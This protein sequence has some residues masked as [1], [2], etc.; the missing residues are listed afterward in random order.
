[1][2]TVVL[3]VA[4]LVFLRQSQEAW[5]QRDAARSEA[6]RARAAATA[7]RDVAA[8]LKTILGAARTEKVEAIEDRFR[9]DL[10]TY[11][12]GFPDE[13]FDYRRL[14][15][16]Q[17]EAMRQRS[18]EVAGVK[19]TLAECLSQLA[20]RQHVH[21]EE[22]RVWREAADAAADELAT[23]RQTSRRDL[24]AGRQREE[25]LAAQVGQARLAGQRL[26]EEYEDMQRRL[27][28]R[29]AE[30]VAQLRALKR[31]YE[32]GRDGAAA[33]DGHVVSVSPATRTV[34]IDRGWEDSLRSLVRLNVYSMGTILP[35][36]EPGKALVEVTRIV[37]AHQAEARVVRDTLGDP[38]LP[39]DPIHSASW[40]PGRPIRFALVG[41]LDMDGDG[42]DDTETLR[43]RI[44]AG[45]GAIDCVADVGGHVEGQ[46]T[47]STRFV[48]VGEAPDAGSPAGAWAAFSRVLRRAEDL[49]VERINLPRLLDVCGWHAPKSED[50]AAASDF[51][52]RLTP[53]RAMPL[54][55]GPAW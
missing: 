36:V 53:R 37:G 38:I 34:H 40:S 42:R 55:D 50:L 19:A 24:A 18:A 48:V 46:V 43:N 35:G 32:S 12:A 23:L 5:A 45:G 6:Q 15:A 17:R 4:S 54:P 26:T 20:A 28:L 49:G 8:R 13:D 7:A 22:V 29:H 11:G 31:E 3:G 44:T 39:G 14:L 9:A 10:A 47:A 33:P 2:L 16:R 1:M 41:R 52:P 21:G 30:V 51:R 27:E 25:E